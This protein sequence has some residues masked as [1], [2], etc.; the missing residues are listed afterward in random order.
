[1][2]EIVFQ[3]S[4]ALSLDG[5][6]RVTVPARH[7][8]LLAACCANQLTLTKHHPGCL[9]MFPRPKWLE[10]RE[11]LMTLGQGSELARRLY[12]GNAVDVEIDS[13][14]RVMIS[15][16]LRDFAGLEKDVMLLGMGSHFELWDG[17]R[18]AEQEAKALAEAQQKAA[19]VSEAIF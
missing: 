15:P 17:A 6:G 14:A 2:S 4:T 3:G 18:Y 7:R 13:G 11:K 19:S 16:E 8:D 1:M 10:V 9:V 12:L 5:K